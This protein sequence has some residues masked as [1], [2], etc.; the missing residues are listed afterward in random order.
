MFIMLF[1]RHNIKNH[2][3]T[4][5]LHGFQ[6]FFHQEIV[7]FNF[8]FTC[9]LLKF[10]IFHGSIFLFALCFSWNIFPQFYLLFRC[11]L[12]DQVTSS[13]AGECG[14][15]NNLG[16]VVKTV[17]GRKYHWD[18]TK[19]WATKSLKCGNIIGKKKRPHMISSIFLIR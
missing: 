17:I 15:L 8:F 2:L 4:F 1:V 7:P 9:E 10:F 14:K 3:N 16:M 19:I 13:V 11:N 5:H 12:S 18:H 6:H